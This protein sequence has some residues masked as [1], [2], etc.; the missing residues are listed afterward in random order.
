MGLESCRRVPKAIPN[1]DC[2]FV[3]YDTKRLLFW[4]RLGITV[5][6]LAIIFS[7][8]D[9]VRVLASLGR[10]RISYALVSLLVGYVMPILIMAWRWQVTLRVLYKIESPYRL[11]LRHYW[12]GMF[13][14]YFVPGGL[15]TDIYRTARMTSEPGGFKLNAA[16]IVG[17]RVFAVFATALLLIASYPPVSGRLVSEPQI[18]RF[19]GFI[20]VSALS[21]LVVLGLAA[22]LNSSLG[23]RLRNSVRQRM[24]VEINRVV[25]EIDGT[26]VFADGKTDGWQLINPFFNWQNQ[27]PIVGIT[28]LCQFVAS[29]GGK[30]L[31]LSIDV[32]LPLLTHLFVWTLMYLF[33]LLPV[34][35][36]GFGIREASFI[37]IL[38]LFGVG[39]ESALASS[40]ISLASVLITVG[41][42]GL[43]WLSDGLKRSRSAANEGA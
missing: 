43:I 34:S 40:F 25:H 37:I 42:G 17:E 2:K 8:I 12:T 14:G 4:L 16:A 13:V 3:K 15:G 39:R 5:A 10:V 33:F 27:L 11:L 7:R 30:F 41:A 28:I 26:S 36:G 6:L 20:Y 29:V 18:A 32:N 9:I 19:V 35:V 38:G 23:G 21:G 22:L 24:G 31:L 1:G